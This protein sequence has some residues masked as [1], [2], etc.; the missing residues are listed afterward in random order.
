MPWKRRV[1]FAVAGVLA[2]LVVV[3]IGLRVAGHL[4]LKRL[5]VHHAK[6]FAASPDACNIVALGE[7]ST[8][9]LWV[10]K[11][12]SYPRQLRGLPRKKHPGIEIN[13]FVPPHVGQNTSQMANRVEDYMRVFSP[14]I[15]IIMAGAN[16]H[17]SWAESHIG[18][19]L[20]YSG[21]DRLRVRA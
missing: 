17:W 9:G 14:R 20:E 5:H 19:F 18:R 16:N 11:S 15:V 4:Y 21:F 7:S 6:R 10:E 8:A 1:L 3:E 2:S 12:K 13:V